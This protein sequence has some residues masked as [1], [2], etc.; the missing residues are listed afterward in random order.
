MS[1]NPLKDF[2]SLRSSVNSSDTQSFYYKEYKLVETSESRDYL[3]YFKAFRELT[4]KPYFKVYIANNSAPFRDYNTYRKDVFIDFISQD[5]QP[6]SNFSSYANT[7][8]STISSYSTYWDSRI[9]INYLS[10][11]SENMTFFGANSSS[12]A[13]ISTSEVSLKS[14]IDYY[15]NSSSSNNIHLNIG[16]TSVSA[17][18]FQPGKQL[19]FKQNSETFRFGNSASAYIDRSYILHATSDSSDAFNEYSSNPILGFDTGRSWHNFC[20]YFTPGN[21]LKI[22]N[23]D[24]SYTT[25]YANGFVEDFPTPQVQE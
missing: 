12:K 19:G 16:K 2:F 17:V 6:I 25:V 20:E 11:S 5:S 4:P 8:Y 23:T 18:S 3:H 24:S 13:I 14:G 22:D 15:I 1:V 7:Y 10:V 21:N 9:Y